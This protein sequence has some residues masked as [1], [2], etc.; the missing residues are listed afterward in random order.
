MKLFDIFNTLPKDVLSV[1]LNKFKGIQK[2]YLIDVKIVLMKCT[3]FQ[4]LLIVD[5]EIF[6]G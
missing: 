1:S 5:A 4:E 6:T 3:F 2:S